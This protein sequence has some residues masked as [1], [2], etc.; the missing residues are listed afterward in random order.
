FALR[1]VSLVPGER[2][3]ISVVAALRMR[4]LAILP[5]MLRLL[6]MALALAAAGCAMPR[7]ARFENAA[8][9]PR[10][11]GDVTPPA[12]NTLTYNNGAEPEGIDPGVIS[13]Q[14]DGRIARAIFEG[15]TTP[16]PRTLEPEPGQ[17][18]RW[19]VSADGLTYTF[20]LRPGLVWSDGRPLS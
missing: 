12:D 10:Y 7:D 19:E 11:F 15:L 17:A 5:P 3:R 9:G 8:A 4:G 20:H 13:G 18:Y 6:L 1:V 16:N 14:P 2:S